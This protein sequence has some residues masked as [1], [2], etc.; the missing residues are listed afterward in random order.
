MSQYT[1]EFYKGEK[2]KKNDRNLN[3]KLKIFYL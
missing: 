1:Y 2:G 3:N